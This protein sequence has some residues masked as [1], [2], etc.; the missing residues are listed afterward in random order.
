MLSLSVFQTIDENKAHADFSQYN[1]QVELAAP[2]VHALS[3]VP[4]L[5]ESKLTSGGCHTL[6]ITSNMRGA[7]RSPARWQTADPAHPPTLP[8]AEKLLDKF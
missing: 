4:Y 6:D 7:A 2:G 8:G 5:D 1:A 3:T